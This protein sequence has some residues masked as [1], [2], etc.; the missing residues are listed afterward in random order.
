M[1]DRTVTARDC[2]HIGKYLRISLLTAR[3]ADINV[4]Y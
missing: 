1:V 4:N 2:A 3:R